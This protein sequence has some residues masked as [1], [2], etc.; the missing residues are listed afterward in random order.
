[1]K[2]ISKIENKIFIQNYNVKQKI[3][4]KSEKKY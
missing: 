2:K 3:L 4:T 1:M